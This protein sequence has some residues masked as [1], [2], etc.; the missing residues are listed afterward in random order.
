M[1]FSGGQPAGCTF[2]CLPRGIWYLFK[3]YFHKPICLSNIFPWQDNY[4]NGVLQYFFDVFKSLL[5]NNICIKQ[6]KIEI[7]N[8]SKT[9]VAT[10]V[11]RAV[12]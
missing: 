11:S 4:I 3:V 7:Q 10:S 6:T 5:K 8:E 9:I 2:K 12:T 1:L